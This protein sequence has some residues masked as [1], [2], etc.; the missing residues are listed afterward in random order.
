MIDYSFTRQRKR[1]K[2]NPE[3]WGV[4]RD[5]SNGKTGGNR[6]TTAVKQVREEGKKGHKSCEIAAVPSNIQQ[7]RDAEPAA[8]DQTK[9]HKT[10]LFIGQS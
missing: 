1:G 7:A 9:L 5:E 4:Q 2:L 8:Q 3:K 6:K 10:D